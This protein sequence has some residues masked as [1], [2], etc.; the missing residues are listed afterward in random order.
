MGDFYQPHPGTFVR[1]GAPADSG[2]IFVDTNILAV[3]EFAPKAELLDEI[4]GD[5][6]GAGD[7]QL[8][9]V[10]IFRTKSKC[11]VYQVES[12]KG[13][14]KYWWP[15]DPRYTPDV[16][17]PLTGKMIR[18]EIPRGTIVGIGAVGMTTRWY[19]ADTYGKGPN[20]RKPP[21]SW[22]VGLAPDLPPIGLPGSIAA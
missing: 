2:M 12:P 15:Y 18:A 11:W 22:R 1:V 19:I 7:E 9:R 5:N 20:R 21:P 14:S 17:N 4:F 10:Q 3:M 6:Q 13:L 8:N 16:D